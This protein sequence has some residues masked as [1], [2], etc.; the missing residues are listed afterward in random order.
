MNS[1]AS[2]DSKSVK[3]KEDLL[4]KNS[5]VLKRTATR[6][7]CR[8]S[9][10]TQGKQVE[11]QANYF[12]LQLP[13][14]LNI[15]RY[16][17][18]IKRRDEPEKKSTSEPKE[19]KKVSEPKGKKLKQIIN[20]R[21][22]NLKEE[23]ASRGS[24]C[25]IATDYKSNLVCT[26]NIPQDFWNAEVT[27]FH[28]NDRAT[29]DSNS[30][31]YFV[32]IKA[33]PPHLTILQLNG[34]LTSTESG[35]QYDLKEPMLQA[36]NILFGHYA[37]STPTTTMVGGNRAFANDQDDDRGFL[38]PIIEAVRGYFLSVRLCSSSSMVNVNVSHSA[39][40]KAIPLID[41]MENSP[42]R[43]GKYGKDYLDYPK[44]E[45]LVKGIHVETKYLK[46]SSKN[47]VTKVFPIKSFARKE[48][49]R[50]QSHPPMVAENMAQPS[51][52]R[53]HLNDAREF[54]KQKKGVLIKNYISVHD[55]FDISM[56]DLRPRVCSR[57]I[58]LEYNIES[59]QDGRYPVI[60]YGSPK[61]PKYV[62]AEACTV[63]PGY[64]SLVYLQAVIE[65]A[66]KWTR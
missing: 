62:P 60:N 14:G 5:E 28:E 33:I 41:F 2:G 30:P 9:Y 20:L 56:S 37:K 15:H 21:L 44:L 17:L 40:Y 3:D 51:K 58:L 47:Q 26:T 46:D 34:F 64:A 55:Y 7:P 25:Y 63:V 36:L 19:K 49:G 24:T 32:H 59:E 42:A 61:D 4:H 65:A 12:R 57:L 66:L 11:L 43:Y 27:Y 48:D 54:E 13:D 39:F 35:A 22:K 50:D 45:T 29:G 16:N 8:P 31:K 10:G 18:E 23:M 38:G 53:F 1:T 52:V 6:Y